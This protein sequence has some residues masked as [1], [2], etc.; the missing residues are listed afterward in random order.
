MS[1]CES[2]SWINKEWSYIL[3]SF[4][5]SI[6]RAILWIKELCILVTHLVLIIMTDCWRLSLQ[7]SGGGH[8]L[9]KFNC[10]I[11]KNQNP[12]A[13]KFNTFHS[14]KNSENVQTCASE[15]SVL[16]GGTRKAASVYKAIH[17]CAWR[18]DRLY[19]SD[20]LS[21]LSIKHCY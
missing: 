18:G 3:E 9:H 8:S 6:N 20:T 14:F 2:Q 11:K 19:R 1:F 21:L 15:P 13:S 12:S 4:Y 16:T 5:L 7:S 10:I 17:A